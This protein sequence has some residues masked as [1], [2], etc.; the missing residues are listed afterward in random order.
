MAENFSKNQNGI[1]IKIASPN[2]LITLEEAR[3]LDMRNDF[4]E[5]VMKSVTSISENKDKVIEQQK[6][7]R[8]KYSNKIVY[9]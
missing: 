8:E 6:E 2:G 9:F 4:K 3:E 5:S 7:L 1:P